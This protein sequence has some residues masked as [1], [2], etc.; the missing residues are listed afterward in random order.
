M[1]FSMKVEQIELMKALNSLKNSTGKGKLT[2]Y[3][4]HLRLEMKTESGNRHLL[5]LQTSN[6]GDFKELHFHVL[7]GTD[8]ISPLIEFEKLHRIVSTIDPMSEITMTQE[9]TMI[10][11]DYTGRREPIMFNGVDSELFP[12]KPDLTKGNAME[13][14]YDVLLG[15]LEFCAPYLTTESPNPILNC[16]NVAIEPPMIKFSAIDN[17]SK[18][19]VY[20]E[21]ATTSLTKGE[22]LVEV[23]ALKKMFP[24][25]SPNSKIQINMGETHVT[26]SQ[27]HI[28]TSLRRI[29]G[30]FPDITKNML[31][32]C[33]AQLT[34]NK[35]EL[36]SALDR[37]KVFV[38]EKDYKAR[39]INV[40]FDNMIS[41]ISLK[42]QL[43]QLD[44]SIVT[45][46]NATPFEMSF[47]VDSFYQSI[48]SIESDDILLEFYS[49]NN[50]LL[51]PKTPSPRYADQRVLV[52]AIQLD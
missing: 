10:R 1:S 9:E 11:F 14:E 21:C 43:G 25:F 12:K 27:S 50:V 51:K 37:V 44:E 48:K 38:D 2:P 24:G 22:F 15:A 41:N 42:S 5:T 36:L 13:L 23:S 39:I 19:F 26:F 16:M 46:S 33:P 34:M 20:G 8:G 7:D 32:P 31:R 40:K 4:K 29:A 6:G 45:Q 18:R 47:L 28:Q 35:Q 3:E 17:T 52:Q 30:S 49:K